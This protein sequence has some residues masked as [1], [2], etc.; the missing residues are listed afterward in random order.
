VSSKKSTRPAPASRTPKIDGTP[1]PA[2]AAEAPSSRVRAADAAPVAPELAADPQ[3]ASQAPPKPAAR[4]ASR[5]KAKTATGRTAK[6]KTSDLAPL[7]P[8]AARARIT[9][10]D[11]PVDLAS[12]RDTTVDTPASDA[13][14]VVT[15]EDIRIRAYFLS[16]E[17]RA[18]GG[19]EMDFWLIAE[20]ELRSGSK[21]KD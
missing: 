20:R 15:D 1:T 16:L 18:R 17:H 9:K 13:T 19:S 8:R 10:A 12:P 7:T 6:P 5:P 11:L 21:P 3:P 14:T 2:I 4:P